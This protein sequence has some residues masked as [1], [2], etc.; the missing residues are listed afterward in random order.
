MDRYQHETLSE[1]EI[2]L[3]DEKQNYLGPKLVLDRC[4]I[5]LRTSSRALTITDAKFIGCHIV[6]ERKLHN[7]GMWCHAR[8]QGCSF[9][10]NYEGNDFGHWPDRHPDG[11]L[12]DCDFADSVLDGCRFIDCDIES[13][14]LP[15]W[16]C[17][18]IINPH[19]QQTFLDAVAWPGKLKHWFGG[20]S[21]SP[22]QTVAIVGYAPTL[23]KKFG[24]SQDELRSLLEPFD[25]VL[26]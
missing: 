5:L 1:A 19:Q 12:S 24:G 20:L 14:K 9:V 10:G 23:V 21:W 13:I 4:R 16:P 15:R 6:A 18:S 26:T 8:I 3:T 7:F 2:V 17:F 22:E 11:H 25:G